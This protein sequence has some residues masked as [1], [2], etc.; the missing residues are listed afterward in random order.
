MASDLKWVFELV[1][2]ATKPLADIE[3]K[4]STLPKSA[5]ATEDALKKLDEAAALK[6]I[7]KMKDPIAQA[8]AMLR[9]HQ[10][11][12]DDGKGAA[13]KAASA[14]SAWSIAGATVAAEAAMKLAG[15]VVRGAEAFA[16]LALE[17][18]QT[19]RSV[20]ASLE[21]IGEGARSYEAI[22]KIGD[23]A[24]VSAKETA[25]AY[26]KLR[27]AGFA[28]KASQDLLSA[29]MD[30]RAFMGGG[31]QG[32]QAAKRFQEIMTKIQVMGKLEGEGF[33]QLASLGVDPTSLA[34]AVAKRSKVSITQAQAL[35][36]QGLVK[37]G[38]LES[39]ILDVVQ[40]KIDKGGPLGTAAKAF[41]E[42]D[43]GTQLDALKNK[44]TAVF[45]N[46]N[47]KPFAGALTSIGKSLDGPM[48]KRLGEMAERAAAFAGALVSDID[49]PGVLD[50]IGDAIDFAGKMIGPMVAGFKE[51]FNPEIVGAIHRFAGGV[52]ASS[53]SVGEMKL[54]F[55]SIGNVIGGAITVI[56]TLGET[57]RVAFGWLEK[58]ML[59]PSKAGAAFGGAMK[60][61]GTSISEGFGK[62]LGVSGADAGRG[63]GDS[64]A[65]GTEDSLEIRSPSRRYR[66]MRER[67]TE[68]WDQGG[69]AKPLMVKAPALN[70]GAS[71]GPTNGGIQ[72]TIGDIIVTGSQ[73]AAREVRNEVRDALIGVLEEMAYT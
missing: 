25:E 36:K 66:R 47:F 27:N 23:A 57:V 56:V 55:Q 28:A 54:L 69:D 52:G 26:M 46:A 16:G 7:A 6:K 10:K 42:G 62:F 39:A 72:I 41:G 13:S 68:G 24:G 37:T 20:L 64:V 38:T 17:A 15:G 12:L 33:T 11:G 1:D 5:K 32:L 60:E 49:V 3:A 70:L 51:A 34:E 9:H 58:L 63:F 22:R 50:S 48:G 4:M 18:S 31:E 61:I 14:L 19:K 44:F 2:K 29:S 59:L 53:S 40:K 73:E 30:V 45:E 71:R 8:T 67:V 35:L 65:K 21:A 43:V